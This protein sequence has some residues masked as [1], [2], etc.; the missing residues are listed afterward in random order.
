MEH[1]ISNSFLTVTIAERGAEIQSITAADGTE[2]FW[3]AN[4][5]I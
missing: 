1:K 2:I 4:K 3:D 5:N